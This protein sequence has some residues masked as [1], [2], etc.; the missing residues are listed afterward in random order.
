MREPYG[1][2]TEVYGFK[3]PDY[4][5]V[6]AVPKENVFEM[7]RL[8]NQL[9]WQM[10]AHTTGGASTDLLLDAY[11]ATD[12]EKSIRDRRFV[13]THANFPNRSVIERSRRM[14]VIL[15]MQPAWLH[16]DGVALS[17]VLGPQRV[18][19]FHPYKSALDAGVMVAGG[20]DHMIKFDSRDAINPFNPFFGMWMAVTRKLT[21]GS[22][23]VPEQRITREQALRMWTTNAAYASFD[24]KNKGSIEAGKLA[25]LVVISKDFLTCPEDEIRSLETVATMVGG[26]FVHQLRAFEP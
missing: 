14:G 24:E 25:D 13:L 17:K 5:G 18:L 9:G 8:A 26:R 20:S 23:L 12:R 3:D 15:D 19:D 21:D 10:T 6:L 1:E 7:A 11:E 4:R 2:H 16:L 22:V